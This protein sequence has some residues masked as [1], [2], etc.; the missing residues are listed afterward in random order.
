MRTLGSALCNIRLSSLTDL[1]PGSKR[2]VRAP[3]ATTN[4]TAR[5]IHASIRLEVEF[6]KHIL[7]AGIWPPGVSARD[8]ALTP[9]SGLPV[10]RCR[11]E[12]PDHRRDRRAGEK[13]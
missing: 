13:S 5:A 3:A 11:R 6:M 4:S 10:R 7:S 12:W 9:D 2:K 1:W 8:F